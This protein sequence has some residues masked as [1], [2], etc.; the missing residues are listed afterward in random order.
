M[1]VTN[2]TQCKV[3]H[4]IVKSVTYIFLFKPSYMKYIKP[5]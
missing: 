2:S 1:I 4:Q 3:G 5:W